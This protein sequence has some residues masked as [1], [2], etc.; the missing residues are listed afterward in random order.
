M[1]PHPGIYAMEYY[2]S[3]SAKP[4]QLGRIILLP[5]KGW[6]ALSYG[7]GHI[8]LFIWA[9]KPRDLGAKILFIWSARCRDLGSEIYIPFPSKYMMGYILTTWANNIVP[10]SEILFLPQSLDLG[11]E[12]GWFWGAPSVTSMHIPILSG[13]LRPHPGCG[14]LYGR[15]VLS[16]FPLR[17]ASSVDAQP[18]GFPQWRSSE[19][20]PNQTY[21][22]CNYASL[23][24]FLLSFTVLIV[25]HILLSAL[26]L[27]P[28]LV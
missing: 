18:L 28:Y 27:S 4:R 17:P 5:V 8:I 9:A 25:F 20:S 14:Q 21:D 2:F 10:G 26:E 13:H 11:Q 15:Y 24:L 12:S 22:L 16:N 1:Q 23:L 6:W 19:C 7:V 3:G